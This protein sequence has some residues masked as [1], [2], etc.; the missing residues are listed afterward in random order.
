LKVCLS[1]ASN[2]LTKTKIIA[3]VV[4]AVAALIFVV[5]TNFDFGTSNSIAVTIATHR[6]VGSLPVWVAIEE[7]FFKARGVDVKMI[8]LP[9]ST[10]SMQALLTGGVNFAGSSPISAF[11]LAVNE[12]ARLKLVHVTLNNAPGLSQ[13]VVRTGVEVKTLEEL[14]GKTI[15]VDENDSGCLEC[16][17]FLITL[18]ENGFDLSEDIRITR[19]V[20]QQMGKALEDGIIDAATMIQPYAAFAITEGKGYPLKDPRLGEFGDA[21]TRLLGTPTQV[22]NNSVV[23][24]AWLATAAYWTTDDYLQ[25]NPEAFHRVAIA[26]ADASVWLMEPSNKQR[27]TDIL[28]K[29]VGGLGSPEL[30]SL[31]AEVTLPYHF[32]KPYPDG[33]TDWLA[34]QQQ[35]KLMHR[36]GVLKEPLDVSRLISTPWFTP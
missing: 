36:L 20:H 6:A 29:Y 11:K 24:P 4:L 25:R 26:L 18:R 31:S 5:V 10:L 14:K 2:T 3:F 28:I 21:S 16:L 17:S 12:D 35:V 23:I 13:L 30:F 34:L 15:A 9:T 27:R 22:P 19:V 33:Y 1:E 32:W 8:E 7:G